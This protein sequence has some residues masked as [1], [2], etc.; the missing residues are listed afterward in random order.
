MN[1]SV[2]FFKSTGDVGCDDFHANFSEKFLKNDPGP[3]L[4]SESEDQENMPSK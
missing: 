4:V 3:K 1:L 2:V